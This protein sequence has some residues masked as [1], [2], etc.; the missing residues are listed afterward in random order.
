MSEAAPNTIA[1]A[2]GTWLDPHTAEPVAHPDLMRRLALQQ[3]VLLGETHD[4]YDVHRWQLHVALGLLA[5]RSDIVLG[6]EMFPRRLQPV[7]DAFIAG[8]FATTEEF[9]EAAEWDEVWRFDPDLYLPL[10]HFCRQFRLPMLALNCSR[11][12]V[13]RVGKEG[14]AAIP[15]DERD[16]L[17]PARPALPAY[18]DYLGNI[19][20]P[21]GRPRHAA[22]NDRFVRAQQTWDRA[23]ACNIARALEGPA[24]P[25]V[26]GIIG[27]GHL[28]YGY[29]TPYQLADLGI[30]R[31]SICLSTD[32][33]FDPI[34]QSDIADALF[35]LPATDGKAG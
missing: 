2:P 22:A 26:I 16:G 30:D 23:F 10:F 28:E 27:R 17:T 21:P 15:V 6:F 33:P 9:L 24:P 1:I 35:R 25:L 34:G 18:R 31:V 14:W 8:T 11:P 3:V 32:G 20:G 19:P 29:G 13:T 5:H 12:L 7:L 4:R